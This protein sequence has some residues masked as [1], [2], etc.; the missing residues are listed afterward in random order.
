MYVVSQATP[1]AERGTVILQLMSLLYGMAI[2][3]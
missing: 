1:T 3:L 2:G